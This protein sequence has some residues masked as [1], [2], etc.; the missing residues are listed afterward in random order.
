MTSD[1]FTLTLLR[2]GESNG[3]AAG[4]IQGQQDH[5]LT[6]TGVRQ[7]QALAARWKAQHLT[8][9]AVFASPLLRARQTAEIVA[10][11]LGLKVALD[12]VWMER[13]FGEGEGLT[14]EQIR[15]Q[16]PQADFYNPFEPAAAG[17]ES[18][19]E[20][21]QRALTGLLRLMRQPAERVLVVSHGALLNMLMFAILGLAPQGH[22]NSPRFRFGNTGFAEWRYSRESRQWYLYSFINPEERA[23][24]VGDR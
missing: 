1:T 14:P 21:Y 20:V 7:A 10:G 9:D 13:N 5:P 8:F 19:V 23:G 3:N 15:E 18:T 11:T 12:E 16:N 6:E 24:T 22:R 17:G 4:I 2:H